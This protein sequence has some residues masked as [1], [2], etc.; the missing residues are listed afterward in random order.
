MKKMLI[1]ICTLMCGLSLIFSVPVVSAEAN[2]Q[3][4]NVFLNGELITFPNQQPTIVDRR[5]LI[6]LRGIFEKMGYSISWDAK[7]KSCVI[8]NEIQTITM[9][10]GHKGMQVDDRAYMLDVP[11]Q[12][13]NDSLMIPLRAVAE[14]T[15]ATVT[16]DAPTKAIYINSNQK[17]Q[18]TYSVDEFVVEYTDAI[19]GLDD[20]DRLFNT[21]NSLTDK[22]YSKNIDI[23]RVESIKAKESLSKAYNELSGMEAP[24]E[25][26][27]LRDLALEALEIS[28]ELCDLV[29]RMID[30]DLTYDEATVEIK[31]ISDMTDKINMELNNAT[32]GLNMSLYR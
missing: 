8:F 5:T 32:A 12:I 18:I 3:K 2:T 19:S 28:I 10:S 1:Y 29:D 23:L 7:T 22:N 21:L 4:I 17:E 31:V 14:C 25:Y 24:S 15:G 9:R 16:W 27:G 30:G 11:A 13:I 20:A 6:P 26:S